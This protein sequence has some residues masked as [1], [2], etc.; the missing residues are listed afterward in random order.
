MYCFIIIA[1]NFLN[2]LRFYYFYTYGKLFGSLSLF[3]YLLFPVLCLKEIISEGLCFFLICVYTI[4]SI[5][6]NYKFLPQIFIEIYNV[7]IVQNLCNRS[8]LQT[9]Q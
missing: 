5:F 3:F 6:H 8:L 7:N 4:C 9:V 2:F 1:A